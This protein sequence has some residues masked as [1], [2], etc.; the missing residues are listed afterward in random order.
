MVSTI[1]DLMA[2]FSLMVSCCS[3]SSGHMASLVA[4]RGHE[5]T[6]KLRD[7]DM[8]HHLLMFSS[9]W[10]QGRLAKK[11]RLMEFTIV[12]SSRTQEFELDLLARKPSQS[13]VAAITGGKPS[14]RDTRLRSQ[15]GTRALLQETS[16]PFT[17]LMH[18]L[19]RERGS[20][21]VVL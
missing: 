3:R 15:R 18:K 14:G 1:R 12:L 6:E 7:H 17:H 4:S 10:A 9:M 21:E 8:R 2:S 20:T 11:I 19:L 5:L 16:E 13:R